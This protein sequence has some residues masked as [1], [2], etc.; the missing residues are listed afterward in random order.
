VGR[1]FRLHDLGY[2]LLGGGFL[3]SIGVYF[4]FR[5]WVGL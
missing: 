1:L 2:G 3:I 4:S 5:K